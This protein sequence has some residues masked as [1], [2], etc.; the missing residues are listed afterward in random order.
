M[1]SWQLSGKG[2]CVIVSSGIVGFEG[3]A[4]NA[5]DFT[6]DYGKLRGLLESSPDANSYAMSKPSVCTLG[7]AIQERRWQDIG[8]DETLERAITIGYDVKRY[9]PETPSCGRDIL[10]RQYSSEPVDAHLLDT[11]QLLASK[12]R[13]GEAQKGEG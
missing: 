10:T 5:N 2:G 12:N 8:S 1:G 11:R 4:A 6:L 13:Y 3:K 7:K 9:Y